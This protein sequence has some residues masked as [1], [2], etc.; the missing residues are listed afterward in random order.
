[1]GYFISREGREGAKMREELKWPAGPIILKATG[2]NIVF[3]KGATRQL[4][5]FAHL[6]TFAIFARNLLKPRPTKNPTVEAGFLGC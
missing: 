6:R 1:L 2:R 5:P 3:L 4:V